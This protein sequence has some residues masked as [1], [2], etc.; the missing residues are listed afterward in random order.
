MTRFDILQLV[1]DEALDARDALDAALQYLSTDDVADL[2]VTNG[3]DEFIDNG[4]GE[5]D[6]E[7]SF[8]PDE[9][10]ARKFMP[11]GEYDEDIYYDPAD[12]YKDTEGW[13]NSIEEAEDDYYEND[14]K[15][16]IPD[17]EE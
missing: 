13:H 6:D 1:D 3:W 2:A 5:D 14:Y 17:D 8:D 4:W 9:A 11:G 15:V 16:N 12:G 10:E 7:N